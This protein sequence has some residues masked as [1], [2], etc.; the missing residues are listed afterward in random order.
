M[1][2]QHLRHLRRNALATA[3]FPQT[4]NGHPV[5]NIPIVPRSHNPPV[6]WEPLPGR[7]FTTSRIVAT[8]LVR[9]DM[10]PGSPIGMRYYTMLRVILLCC[11]PRHPGTLFDVTI[12]GSPTNIVP[13]ITRDTARN[14]FRA[15]F[16]IALYSNKIKKKGG[17]Y[18]QTRWKCL[19]TSFT[20]AEPT[21]RFR[22]TKTSVS[23][24]LKR[25]R[26][27]SMKRLLW[28]GP[29]RRCFGSTRTAIVRV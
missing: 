13:R 9:Y 25:L 15:S 21:V 20:Y 19:Y 12:H 26:C 27:I 11:R 6:V 5:N 4:I 1:A 18:N 17:T 24:G 14:N 8:L 3:E 16:R 29:S 10:P 2:N 7:G 28:V 23:G 22:V